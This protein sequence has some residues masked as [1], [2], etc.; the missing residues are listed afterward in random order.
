MFAS[1]S[2]ERPCLPFRDEDDSLR[3]I[4]DAI[5]MIET[6]TSGADFEA[7]SQDPKTVAAVER[8]LQV[9]SEAAMGKLRRSGVR[10]CPRVTSAASGI[11][12]VTSTNESSCRSSGKPCNPICR[13]E[14]RGAAGAHSAGIK[15]R[16]PGCHFRPRER[17]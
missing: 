3:D 16:A 13:P 1:G 12:C 7:F 5:E 15:N 10:A 2:R 11:G 8:K 4:V 9:I 6:F 17:G 14:A